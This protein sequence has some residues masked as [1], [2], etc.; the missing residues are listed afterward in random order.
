M[1]VDNA[2]SFSIGR[3]VD[4]SGEGFVKHASHL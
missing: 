3:D 1:I 4:V 2:K